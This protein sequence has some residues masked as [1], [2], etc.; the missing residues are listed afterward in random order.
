MILVKH[1]KVETNLKPY[2]Y[3]ALEQYILENILKDDEAYFFTWKIKGIVIGKNQVLENE[4]NLDYTKE[5]NIDIY[6]RPTGGGAI[7]ADENNSMF[8][9][10]T[11]KAE[12]FSF[13]KYLN[14]IIDAMQKLGLKIE[15]SGRND[16]LYDNKKMSGVAFLQNKYGVLIHGTY[17]YDVNVETMIRSITPSNEKLVSKGID[18]VRS[19]VVNLKDHLNGITQDELINHLEKEI[20]TKEYILSPQEIDIITEMAKKYESK[21]WRFQKQPPYTKVIK[22]RISGGVFE[23]KLDLNKGVIENAKIT[24]D[25]FDLFPIELIEKQ[26]TNIPYTKEAITNALNTIN[27]E[28]MI[29]DIKKDEFLDLLL[30]GLIE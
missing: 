15:F 26:L 13:K 10:I 1:D 14:L 28:D 8:T 29:L 24:G 9:M 7:Y 12:N 27:L 21:E 16:L 30:E 17:M 5:N 25:F 6:R 3:F 4:V 18:S 22:K 11:K 20:T 2:F 23:I 19:R